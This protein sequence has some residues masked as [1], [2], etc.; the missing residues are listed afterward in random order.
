MHQNISCSYAFDRLYMHQNI[1]YSPALKQAIHV[2]DY[3]S[4]VMAGCTYIRD[5]QQNFSSMHARNEIII[6]W[7]FKLIAGA[8]FT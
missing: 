2:S 6:S 5:N 8:P 7:S 4:S 3:T 1:V